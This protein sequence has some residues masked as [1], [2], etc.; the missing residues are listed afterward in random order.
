MKFNFEPGVGTH[1]ACATTDTDFYT[2]MAQGDRVEKSNAVMDYHAIPKNRDYIIIEMQMIHQDD[3]VRR[4]L[5]YTASAFA[6]QNSDPGR[7]WHTRI[8]KVYAIQFLDY[9]T[10]E[11]GDCLEYYR[12][13]DQLSDETAKGF[14]LFKSN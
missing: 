14:A 6:K 11:K 12:V 2:M 10:R 4:A 5:F 13:R 9:T 3:V 7:E 1:S 8:A